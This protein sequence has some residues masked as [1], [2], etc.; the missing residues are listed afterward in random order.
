MALPALREELSL[1]PGPCAPDGTP[2]WTVHDPVRN[3]FFEINWAGF[4]IL[5][6]WH[7]GDAEKIAARVNA[8]TTLEVSSEDVA[9]MAQF[10]AVN[11]LTRADTPQDMARLLKLAS[12][13]KTTAAQWL[14]HHYLFFRI[15]LTRPDALLGKILPYVRWLGSRGFMTATVAAFLA[16]LFFAA[17]QW[18]LFEAT[19]VDK[20][21]VGGF[22]SFAVAYT[23]AKVAH[24]LAHALTA[25]HHGCRVP[26]MGIAFLVMWPV[27]YTDVNDVWKLPQRRQRLFVGT[28]GVIAELTIASWALLAWSF[29]PSGPLQSAAFA[30]TATT[31]AAS[32]AI[33]LSPFMRFDGYY[34]LMD[35]FN[36][37][38]LHQRSFALGK[39]YIRELVFGLNRQP[40]EALSQ[41]RRRLLICFAFAT[42]IYR[43]VLFI[44]IALLVYHFF[45][46]VAGIALFCVEI[47]WFVV[48]P[49]YQELKI[50]KSL[51]LQV[52]GKTKK[53][54]VWIFTA[55]FLLVV[56]VPWSGHLVVPAMLK[57]SSNE[58]LYVPDGAQLR[59]I[60]AG[61]GAKVKKGDILFVFASPDIESKIQAATAKIESA[62]Y[63]LSSISFDPDFRER[64]DIA[65]QRRAT[66][67]A[68]R[69]SL[70]M[71][72]ARLV[73]TAPEDG[74]V[75]DVLPN[76]HVGDWLSPRE[77]LGI[78]LPKSPALI[79][80]YVDENGRDRIAVGDEGVFYPT[81]ALHD[82]KRC[83]VVAIETNP[84]Q[85]LQDVELAS[86][87]G[88]D[89][90]VRIA[91]DRSYGE[92][93][94]SV[95]VPEK[96]IYRV[97]LEVDSLDEVAM[98][99]SGKVRIAVNGES[100]LAAVLRWGTT[101]VMR[102]MGM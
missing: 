63:V 74:V 97:Q 18:D 46:K 32:L 48:L 29:L 40:P 11:Q 102:E 52:D 22:F 60:R 47:G 31:L 3:R 68:E 57:A 85:R 8:E 65:R 51:Y 50:W 56:A 53:K 15:P 20:M 25:K 92:E 45:F 24:E 5:S 69:L 80:A 1:H 75:R 64:A 70:Q 86:P 44:G 81:A 49:L 59:E 72:A 6:R 23:V 91:R 43:L 95:P 2:T 4:E 19:L 27:L 96:A 7:E 84:V 76:M 82:A 54:Q 77:R 87:L 62:S 30:L 66:A 83:R 42:W 98:R 33:N 36:I 14:L 12:F 99:Q 73:I 26:T 89:I 17:R 94:G 61:E 55:L 101:V 71:E 28:A 78:F 93:A 67:E 37:P 21:T 13:E 90:L 34:V 41:A 16:G 39:W 100:L 9:V 10:L 35:F 38:N 79:D 88:G 58:G